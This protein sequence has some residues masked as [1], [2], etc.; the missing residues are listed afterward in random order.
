MSTI[1]KAFVEIH[2]IL[3]SNQDKKVGE[4]MD[5]LLELMESKQR[6]KNHEYR[7]GKLYIFCYYHKEWECVDDIE[8]GSK[9]NTATGYNTMCKIGVNCWTKQ[10]R[11]FKQAKSALLDKVMS[12]EIEASELDSEIAKLE[13]AKNTIITIKGY[14]HAQKLK[15]K[16]DDNE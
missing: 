13:E 15:E 1:K 14:E 16:Q 11:D 5:Q 6:D 3:E 10:Q 7:D 9:A 8:Y 4:L 2:N 12:G